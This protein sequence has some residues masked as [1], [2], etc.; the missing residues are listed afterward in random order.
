MNKKIYEYNINSY[1]L[2][3]KMKSEAQY[4]TIFFLSS[5]LVITTIIGEF[6]RIE[7]L[8]EG[9]DFGGLIMMFVKLVICSLQFFLMI[10]NLLMWVI[11]VALT[12][13]PFF[14]IWLIQFVICAFKMLVNIPNCFL[15]YGLQIAGK[16]LYLPFRLT[17]F[18]LDLLLIAMSVG[19]SIQRLVD[20][21]WFFMDDIDHMLYDSG[22]GFH[23]LHY[24][25]EINERCY[26]CDI[27]KF[28][29]IPAFPM[30]AVNAFIKCIS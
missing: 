28:P 12:W 22:S 3:Y 27:G 19:F 10:F 29:T 16:I 25:D 17:F 20:Q 2:Y 30:S 6:S 26:S 13:L 23:F 14:I 9:M 11:K 15:W 21:G 18:V 5:V 24:P 8:K 1:N 4:K 7:N